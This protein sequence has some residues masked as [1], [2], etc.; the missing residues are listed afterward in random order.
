MVEEIPVEMAP[1][2]VRK[3]S[4]FR[5]WKGLVLLLICLGALA[6]AFFSWW[7]STG[8]ISSVFAR[9]DTI[10]YTVEPGFSTQIE[11]VYVHPGDLVKAG[12]VLARIDSGQA[13]DYMTQATRDIASL[14][15]LPGMNDMA[16]RLS[17]AQMAEKD[18]AVRLAQA[19][20]H[21]D[22]LR[23]NWEQLTTEHVRAQ[24]AKRSINPGNQAAY[25]QAERVE[26]SAKARMEAA[27]AS[28][29]QTSKARAALEI[30]LNRIRAELY[31]SG[32]ATSPSVLASS[33]AVPPPP[34]DDNLYAPVA[35]RVIRVECVPRQQV[36][37]GTPLFL[38]MPT[39]V[40]QGNNVWIQA[41]F[42]LDSRDKLKIGQ[43]TQIKF[44]NRDM[45]LDGRISAIAENAQTLPVP[46][47]SNATNI[48]RVDNDHSRFNATRF[49]P[50]RIQ[51]DDP[52]RAASLQPG[53]KAECLIQT[54]NILGE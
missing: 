21:E 29:E 44:E 51:L 40:E 25:Q 27:K 37:R 13:G 50:V 16:D 4:F 23:A 12:Q 33:T 6:A 1:E 41:W 39:G 47:G 45:V 3:N 19:R 17:S 54:R 46:E 35:G 8:K 31:R 14:R 20:A 34:A 28:F 42:P 10:I 11:N 52:A 5:S 49:L 18:M 43:K 48:N 9:L 38:I 26:Q 2:R 53:V 7:L 22:N 32:L 36:Q 30:E 24:L 15:Q